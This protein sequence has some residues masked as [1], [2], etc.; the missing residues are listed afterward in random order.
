[1]V[2]MV[3]L[4]TNGTGMSKLHVVSFQAVINIGPA[5]KDKN[6]LFMGQ[7]D[8]HALILVFGPWRP[9]KNLGYAFQFMGRF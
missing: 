7:T 3:A 4:I 2:A 8:E 1:M 9:N 6:D 5:S